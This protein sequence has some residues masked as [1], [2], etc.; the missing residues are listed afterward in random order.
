MR[1][2]RQK[3]DDW[4][5]IARALDSKTKEIRERGHGERWGKTKPFSETAR[6]AVHVRRIMDEI[7]LFVGGN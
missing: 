5:E 6:W 1:K 3:A 2:P 4:T 7:A